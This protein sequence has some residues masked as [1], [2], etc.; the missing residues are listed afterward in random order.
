GSLTS[1]P[2]VGNGAKDIVL[3]KVDAFGNLV[4]NKLMGGSGDEDVNSI[5][6]TNDGGLLI[7]GTNTVNGLGTI[8]LIKTNGDGEIKN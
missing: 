4:W 1:T 8:F 7:S 3:I 6:E 2:A 5:R